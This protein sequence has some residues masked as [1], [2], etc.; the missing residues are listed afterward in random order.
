[1]AHGRCGARNELGKVGRRGRDAARSHPAPRPSGMTV[2]PPH[3]TI[4][5]MSVVERNLDRRRSSWGVTDE[6]E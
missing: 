6:V 4:R 5:A 2:I 1:M 3:N